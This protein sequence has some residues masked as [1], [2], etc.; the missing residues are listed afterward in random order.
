MS[1]QRD[2]TALTNISMKVSKGE[3]VLLTGVSGAGKS[4]L[5]KLLYCAL[6]ASSGQIIVDGINIT[7]LPTSQVPCLR[8]KVGVV[9][10]DFKLLS[11]RSVLENVGLTL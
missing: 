1:Y 2:A 9:F 11:N 7:N 8:R 4:T 6:R 3:F 10:Q 5:L